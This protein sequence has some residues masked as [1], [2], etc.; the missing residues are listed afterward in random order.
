M[1]DNKKIKLAI[2]VFIMVFILALCC[3]PPKNYNSKYK[4]PIVTPYGDIE[5]YHPKVLYFNKEW[6]GYKYWMS[7]T[8]Y[9]KGDD[10]KENPCI[11]VSN[12]LITW[13][14]PT[15][16]NEPLDVP[17]QNID[18]VTYNSD[19]HIVYNYDLDRIECYWRLVDDTKD[20]AILYRMYTKDGRNWSPKEISAISYE[21]EKKLDYVSPAII[22][23]NHI[24]KMWY[25]NKNNTVTYEESKDGLNWTNH[26]VV[27]IK[28]EDSK[29]KTWHLDV[30]K[31]EKGYEMITV[32]FDKWDNHN[33][34]DLYYTYSKN[35]T[36][37]WIPAKSILSPTKG[38]TYWDNRGIYRSSFIYIDGIYYVYYSGTSKDLHHGIGLMYGKDIF[39]LKGNSINYQK[40]D[41]VN[42]LL[43]NIQKERNYHNKEK[44]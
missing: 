6:N 12:N 25:V 21:R 36:K 9:P 4:M 27:P 34:M 5:A 38:T 22:Y 1:K 13:K 44:K 32:A 42:R 43:K 41:E 19:S 8:P 7:Y 29:Q 15:E 16:K 18:M 20:Q 17:Y 11:A 2:I 28:Y 24:Y 33:N 14:S 10:S 40:S 26:T 30:I 3:I 23:E 31:T 39:N 37:G 35:E